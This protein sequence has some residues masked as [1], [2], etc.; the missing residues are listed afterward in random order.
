MFEPKCLGVLKEEKV[1]RKRM[2]NNL[3]FLFKKK[4]EKII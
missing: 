3:Y 2:D 1:K 4:K